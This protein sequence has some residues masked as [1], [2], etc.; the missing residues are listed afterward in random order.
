MTETLAISLWLVGVG[1]MAAGLVLW[2]RSGF[3]SPGF[4]Y[5]HGPL[6]MLAYAIATVTQSTVGLILALRRPANLQGWLTLLFGINLAVGGSIFGTLSLSRASGAVDASDAWLA[7]L[8]TWLTLPLG[9]LMSVAIGFIFPNGRLISR[10]WWAWLAVV[11]VGAIS[12]AVALAL[13][14]GPL[15]LYPDV[16]NP[17]SGPGSGGGPAL[18]LSLAVFAVGAPLTGIALVRRYAVAGRIARLQIRWFVFL[19]LGLE[20]AFLVF[21]ASLARLPPEE[22]MGEVVVAALFLSTALPAV[23]LLV[24]ITRY[25]LYDIDTLIS[26]T[27]VYGALTAILGTLY[28]TSLTVFQRLFTSVT[29][30]TSDA[31]IIFTTLVLTI[32]FNPV[33]SRL[34]RFMEQRWGQPALASAPSS[35][36]QAILDDPAFQATLD[37][38][39]SA[40]VERAESRSGT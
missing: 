35:A 3:A 38:R 13:T 27:F 8:N 34:E 39:V 26:R 19:S 21:L 31:A 37:A 40:A 22:P 14:P 28:A 5:L 11:T 9:T 20:A 18:A 7:W 29:G 16:I 1:G 25:R 32:S 6:P 17:L 36:A 33:K 10:T 23:A 4:I 15:L 30:E 12:T 2:S 24:A